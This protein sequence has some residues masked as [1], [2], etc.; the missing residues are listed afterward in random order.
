MTQHTQTPAQNTRPSETQRYHDCAARVMSAL[1][2]QP[3]PAGMTPGIHEQIVSACQN[4]TDQILT[5]SDAA[6]AYLIRLA[7]E[8]S[9]ETGF[10]AAFVLD[11]EPKDE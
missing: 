9:S 4:V 2:T 3:L 7:G 10:L 1:R 5:H 8:N 11:M 6:R